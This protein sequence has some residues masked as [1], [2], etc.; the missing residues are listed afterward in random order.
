AQDDAGYLWFGSQ[1]GL[2]RYDG[3][4]FTIYKHDPNDPRS[5]PAN[6]IEVLLA[7]DAGDTWIG[8][9]YG[10]LARFDAQSGDFET[11]PL[12]YGDNARDSRFVVHALALHEG[13][14]WA[15][16]DRGLARLDAGV[17][18]LRLHAVPGV[19]AFP[20][21]RA[22]HA[23]DTGLW[24]G[25]VGRVLHLPGGNVRVTR[26]PDS[27]LA[28]HA[29]ARDAARTLVAGTHSGVYRMTRDGGFT[30]I[31]ALPRVPFTTLSTDSSGGFWAGGRGG[32]FRLASP[33]GAWQPYRHEAG[34]PSSVGQDIVFDVFESRD[35]VLWIGTYG[36]GL[37]RAVL[38]Q[39]HFG[40]HQQDDDGLNSNIIFP[41]HQDRDGVVW[42]GTYASGLNR[43]DRAR[44][45]WQH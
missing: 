10:G 25:G 42:I 15:A 16:T 41:I 14:L 8:T 30:R 23:D 27:G 12:L 24:V 33:G 13:E 38:S 1:D 43:W 11:V 36:G 34:N 35:K 6:Y 21:T 29:L 28:V 31:A 26:L 18:A 19:Q 44:D 20:E 4:R 7:G 3:H 39:Q 9:R 17:R 5:I 37:S 45:E 32:V 40:L 22:L 2:N